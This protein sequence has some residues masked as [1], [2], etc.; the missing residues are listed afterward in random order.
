MAHLDLARARRM[1]AGDRETFEKFFEDHFDAVFRFA[2][3]RLGDESMA[4]E[5]V[6]S[7]FCLAV[8]KLHTYRGEATLLSW[9]CSICRNEMNAQ[10][11]LRRRE[12]TVSFVDDSPEVRSILEALGGEVDT[13]EEETLRREAARLVHLTLDS[14]PVHYAQALE[15]KYFEGVT[16]AEIARRL[17]TGTKAAESTLTRAR[18]AFSRVFRT[19]SQDLNLAGGRA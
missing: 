8:E 7:T 4:A 2:V 6:Q 18:Q 16:V 15:W 11:R 5:V 10:F 12:T 14:L 9:L 17:D 13:V 19:A 1:L 3:G